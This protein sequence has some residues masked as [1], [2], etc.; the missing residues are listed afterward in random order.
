MLGTGEEILNLG[1]RARLFENKQHLA[2]A[3]RRAQLEHL[4]CDPARD[5]SLVA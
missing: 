5:D 4:Y 2:I 1:R 3:G